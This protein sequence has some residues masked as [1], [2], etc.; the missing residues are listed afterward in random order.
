MI[1]FMCSVAGGGGILLAFSSWNGQH[2][3]DFYLKCQEIGAGSWRGGA[4]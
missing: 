1:G 3:A 2:T 4:R